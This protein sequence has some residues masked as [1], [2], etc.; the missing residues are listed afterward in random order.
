LVYQQLVGSS[1]RSGADALSRWRTDSL[2]ERSKHRRLLSLRSI[3]W[4][5]FVLVFRRRVC[6][7]E[8]L[9]PGHLLGTDPNTIFFERP[10]GIN[11]S[12]VDRNVG[13]ERNY[14]TANSPTF[15]LPGGNRSLSWFVGG[16]PCCSISIWAGSGFGSSRSPS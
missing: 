8:W 11:S 13:N 10:G 7:M 14:S 1:D 5:V 12:P 16:Q 2:R 6:G 15:A 9:G 4:S 3:H